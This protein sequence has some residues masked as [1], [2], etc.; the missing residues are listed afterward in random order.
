MGRGVRLEPPVPI[1]TNTLRQIVC[2]ID[3]KPGT[4]R[5]E[6]RATPCLVL[7]ILPLALHYPRGL[8][9]KLTAQPLAL[10]TMSFLDLVAAGAA[11]T[12]VWL[13]VQSRKPRSHYLPPGPKGLPIIGVGISISTN[14]LV[15][16][17]CLS[18]Y[19]GHASNARMGHLC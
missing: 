19:F 13:F 18:E 17:P 12:T 6:D 7:W 10:T 9:G 2:K 14:V 11:V 4:L 3:Q 1:H 16:Y 5:Q 15:T 8:G